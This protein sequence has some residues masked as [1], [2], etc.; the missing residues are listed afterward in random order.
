MILILNSKKKQGFPT[1]FWVFDNRAQKIHFPTWKTERYFWKFIKKLGEKSR[2][3]KNFQKKKLTVYNS[4][5]KLF[6]IEKNWTS[7]SFLRQFY[8]YSDF[9]SAKTWKF[10]EYMCNSMA[11]CDTHIKGMPINPIIFEIFETETHF[12]AKIQGSPLWSSSE[13]TS[14]SLW[15]H[16]KLQRH[17][18]CSFQ[19]ITESLKVPWSAIYFDYSPFLSRHFSATKSL[20]SS[21]N[22]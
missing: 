5:G 10:W 20:M 15:M 1:K 4:A 11:F 18:F 3:L 12:Y 7:F 19:Q 16:F 21:I 22:V 2:F 17:R 6:L 9:F 13:P 14:F 8:Y